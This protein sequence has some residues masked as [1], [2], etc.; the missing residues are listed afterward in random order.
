MFF[1]LLRLSTLY[2]YIF[3]NNKHY[4]NHFRASFNLLS[5]I[6]QIHPPGST[7]WAVNIILELKKEIVTDI[8]K[9]YHSLNPQ[10]TN[11]Y[12]ILSEF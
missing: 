11:I 9:I 12:Y 1:F 10:I 8:T 5:L 2:Y 3:P 6:D 4:R 7:Q